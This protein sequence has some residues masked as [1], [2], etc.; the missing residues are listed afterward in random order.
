M[1]NTTNEMNWA[2][3]ERLRSVELR[4][5]W[6]GH[7]GRREIKEVFGISPAQATSDLQKY[8]ELNGG[9]CFYSTNRKRYEAGPGMTCVLHRPVLEE[10][11]SLV[12]GEMVGDR[13]QRDKLWDHR[14]PGLLGSV[15]LPVRE[16]S[17]DIERLLVMAAG[18]R[19][20]IRVKYS[21][22]NSGKS[23]WRELIPRTFGWDGR[24]WHLRAY[25]PD[26][27]GWRDFVLGRFEEAEWPGAEEG[28][29][30]PADEAWDRWVVVRLK[31][32]PELDAVQRR[33][34]RMDYGLDGSKLE[35]RVREAMRPYLLA[36]MFLDDEDAGKR[37][38]HFVLN[39]KP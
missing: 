2:A 39:S 8:F 31:I 14:K 1:G 32:N 24:R 38:R 6:R 9:A 20:R 13:W 35:V 29:N 11:L 36:E 28:E 16:G 34:L 7:V 5:W 15:S 17:P 18:G 4:L 22:V 30:V 27:E 21:S 26:N 23:R 12:F 19:R 3:R 25:C 10:G 37:P 33:A